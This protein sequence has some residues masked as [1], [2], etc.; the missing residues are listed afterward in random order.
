MAQPL[1]ADSSNPEQLP[2]WKVREDV[3]NEH[4]CGHFSHSW[5]QVVGDRIFVFD[6]HDVVFGHFEFDESL[7]GVVLEAIPYRYLISLP[8]AIAERLEIFARPANSP[9]TYVSS[10]F[11][12]TWLSDGS[13][14]I[15]WCSWCS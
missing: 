13:S 3:M 15:S 4:V 9:K 8:K 11:T 14:S 7:S 10:E 12:W 2:S 6:S 1:F 5:G